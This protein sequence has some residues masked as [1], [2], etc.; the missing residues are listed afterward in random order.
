MT[1][2]IQAAAAAESERPGRAE[3]LST[4]E[5]EP[6]IPEKNRFFFDHP[7]DHVPAMLLLDSILRAAGQLHRPGD[8]EPTA[9][10]M[11]FD[12]FCEKSPPPRLRV[13]SVPAPGG[14]R[15]L[16]ALVLQ[17][18]AAVCRA[19]LRLERPRSAPRPTT[20]V[21]I[22][23]PTGPADPRL[24]HKRCRERV[25]VGPLHDT[26][27]G[28]FTTRALA[29]ADH[30]ARAVHP[31]TLLVETARQA[32]TMV[33]HT[34]W[35]TPLD[36]RLIVGSLEVSLPADGLWPHRLVLRCHPR[37][38]H[39]RHESVVCELLHGGTPRG[40]IAFTGRTVPPAAYRRLRAGASR[41][42]AA[43]RGEAR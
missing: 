35:G 36:Q 2:F 5:G 10:R 1:T 9:L 7:L 19:E 43:H 3:T 20:E 25:L 37:R 29:P 16:D 42:T 14:A 4:V 12:R 32:A 21:P 39:R 26:G 11:R 30:H 40:R 41:T 31:L 22:G 15:L 38:A 28:A 23:P 18:G 34:A 17:S 13:E 27:A 33:S 8:W 24:V 6:A